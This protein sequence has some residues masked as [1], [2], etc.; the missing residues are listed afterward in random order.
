MPLVCEVPVPLLGP[1]EGVHNRMN[2]DAA[3]KSYEP[4]QSDMRTRIGHHAAIL[5]GYARDMTDQRYREANEAGR[6]RADHYD[7]TIRW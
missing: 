4:I 5:P 1:L 3:G 7:N 2:A 6:Y